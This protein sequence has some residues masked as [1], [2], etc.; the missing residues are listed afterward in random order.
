MPEIAI[1]RSWIVLGG[2]CFLQWMALGVWM[3][4]LTLVLAAYGYGALTPLAFA[5][6][7]LAALVTPLFF[8]ALADRQTGPSKALRYLALA[9]AGTMGLASWAITRHWHPAVVLALIQGHAL[10]SA[11]GVSLST[12]VMLNSLK[13]PK[14]EFGPI[15]AMGTVGW[16]VGCWVVSA[17][18]A[19]QS[20]WAG[21]LGAGLW[22][23]VAGY[24]FLLP[25]VPPSAAA[26]VSWKERLGLDALTLLR[27][28]D[29]RVIFLTACLFTMPLAAFYPYS[30]R[31]LQ[32]LGLE[33]ASA[34]MSLG[35][36]TEILGM[37]TLGL[38]ISRLRLKWVLLLALIT[39]LLRFAL[40][41]TDTRIGLLT[42]IALHGFTYSY[43]FTTVQIYL[44][45]RVDPAWRTR[46]QA[47]LSL[48]ISGVG[49]L[50]GYTGT[51]WWLD[52]QSAPDGTT[53][54]TTFWGGLALL[55]TAIA[56]FF[57]C[58]YQGRKSLPT[59]DGG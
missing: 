56:V 2:L 42:G 23:G 28:H 26:S 13:N 8:G 15:R 32:D 50:F 7:A 4:P 57:G 58:T 38:V 1:H 11:P 6:T 9:A 41:A 27:H 14:R 24:S 20:T 10:C 3:V 37:F 29:H 35:Q 16:M 30:P 5:S 47:L 40:N 48:L 59:S 18:G 55:I 46:A 39:G 33:R 21:F 53:D 51:G 19:D 34:W 54:W 31:H 45:E 36:I 52:L 44:N 25:R 43:F 49:H 17:M 22:L 12:T